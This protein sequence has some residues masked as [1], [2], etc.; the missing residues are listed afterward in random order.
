MSLETNFESLLIT[1]L[2]A[3]S[4]SYRISFFIEDTPRGWLLSGCTGPEPERPQDGAAQGI[5]FAGIL[6]WQFFSIGILALAGIWLVT[7]T[8]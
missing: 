5:L 1:S 2:L 4:S 7:H 8:C 3:N 6:F